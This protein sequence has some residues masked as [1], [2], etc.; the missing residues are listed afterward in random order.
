MLGSIL[1][2]IPFLLVNSRDLLKLK[3]RAP[4]HPP[5]PAVDDPLL[6]V[7]AVNVFLVP[8]DGDRKQSDFSGTVEDPI[9]TVRL[10][11]SVA[12]DAVTG[13]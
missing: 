9:A 8:S 12:L 5:P 2:R 11:L 3:L 4:A 1:G 10:F 6:C 7:L 13:T